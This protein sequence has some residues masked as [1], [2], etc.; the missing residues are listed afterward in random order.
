[1]GG[2]ASF[3]AWF[4]CELKHLILKKKK[5]HLS[6]SHH[7]YLSRYQTIQITKWAAG[8]SLTDLRN[9]FLLTN[10]NPLQINFPKMFHA[11]A[12]NHR[13]SILLKYGSE[14]ANI[15]SLLIPNILSDRNLIFNHLHVNNPVNKGSIA[16]AQ[17][18]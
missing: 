8:F 16:I 6:Y 2:N 17:T 3:P 9:R 10:R 13:L 1:M 7:I 15:T 12:L 14:V 5:L 18:S 4:S 11:H